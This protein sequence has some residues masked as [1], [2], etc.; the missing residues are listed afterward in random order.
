MR[1][2]CLGIVIYISVINLL[3]NTDVIERRPNSAHDECTICFYQWK[4]RSPVKL[5]CKHIFCQE[6]ITDQ[7]QRD[8]K[9]PLCSK[10]VSEN[11]QIV[12]DKSL[13]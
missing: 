4:G 7:F 11:F 13:T 3:F 8:F 5:P 10:E 6:C 12:A 1:H 9:C 2:S